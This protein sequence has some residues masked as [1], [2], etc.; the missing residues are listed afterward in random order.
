MK[1]KGKGGRDDEGKICPMGNPF[2]PIFK[3]DWK[4]ILFWIFG[5]G[6]FSGGFVP[7]FEELAKGQGSSGYI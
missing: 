1:T 4:K 6:L 7:A 2:C 3:R 5:V